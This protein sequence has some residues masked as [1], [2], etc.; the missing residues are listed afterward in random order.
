MRIVIVGSFILFMGLVAVLTWLITH[1]QDRQS[2]DG[3]FLAGRKLTFPFIAGSLLLTNLSTEQLVGLNGSA[4]INGL[5]VM[6]WEVVAVVA[7]VL[8]ALFF[9]PRFLRSGIATIPE[10]LETRF[11]HQTR[12]ITNIIFLA[13]YAV[14]LLPIILYSG[15]M[16]LSR[17]LDVQGLLNLPNPTVALWVTVWFI[18]LAG[19]VYAVVGGLRSVAVSDLINGIGLLVGGLLIPY[20]GLVHYADG[21]GALGGLTKLSENHGDMLNSIGGSGSD[22]PFSTL[23]TGLVLLNL[24]Y[25]CTNQ[26]IIQRTFGAS[27]LKEGQKGVLLTGLLKL[28]GPLYLVLPGILAFALF[29]KHGI[30]PDAAY[31]N[32]VQ[33]VLPAPLTGFFAAVMVGA[34]LSSFNSALNSITTLFSLG[35]YKN[36]IKK[37]ASER[38][39]VYAGKAAGWAIAVTSMII[40]PLLANTESIFAYLQKMNGIYFIPLFAVVVVGFLGKRIPAAAAKVGLI[41]GCVVIALGY[42]VPLGEE[43][44]KILVRNTKVA[45]SGE[46]A[47]FHVYL[48]KP[49]DREVNLKL[50]T[51][52][53]A[54]EAE[55]DY[56]PRENLNVTFAPGETAE[57]VTV[58]IVAEERA[59]SDQEADEA[60]SRPNAFFLA[61][62]GEAPEGVPVEKSYEQYK[63]AVATC[64]ILQTANLS[65]EK[66]DEVSEKIETART[67][68]AVAPVPGSKYL[69]DYV[70][71]FH[72][73][74]I[75]FI[76]V[77][78]LMVLIGKIRPRHE[79]W[80]QEDVKAVDMT[81]W[82]G[83]K[84]AAI[85][86][87]VLV[88]LI[89]AVF[90]DF[91]AIGV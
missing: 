56:E 30:K 8:M 17:M 46:A 45:E 52:D 38:S 72:F 10:L 3:Y 24:F 86:L 47:K 65:P 62:S 53:G 2:S 79:P 78:L 85:I 19:S 87:I 68:A 66:Q 50:K 83:A 39:V 16:G 27:S 61:V 36:I 75:A 70:H 21:G 12:V 73:L 40:A 69:T 31:G 25:W 1:K 20:F 22:L 54:A 84:I 41:A 71:E 11:D 35:L 64:Q 5:C 48:T 9:L 6:A 4:F 82:K 58:P 67:E 29:A 13:A 55:K 77:V 34:I 51:V 59:G 89:Y 42:F 37:D 7:L 74:G 28:L 33:T 23:F 57:T 88:F 18:G 44:A 26:Q 43:D 14:I 76:G 91:S 15:A 49:M 90:A 60:A 63:S 80:I 32:L 81:P